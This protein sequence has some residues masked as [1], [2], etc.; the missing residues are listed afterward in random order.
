MRSQWHPCAASSHHN[1]YRAS[2]EAVFS[3]NEFALSG[4]ARWEAC[5]WML[6]KGVPER[7]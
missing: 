1:G 6:G 2:P 4:A 7:L 3:M 5:M